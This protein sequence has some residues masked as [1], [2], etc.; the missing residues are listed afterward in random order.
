MKK[1]LVIHTGGTIA[2]HEDE[3]GGVQPK[4]TNPLFATVESL[5]SIA[6]IEVDDF[7]NIPSPHMTPELMFQLAERLKSRVGNESFDGVVIT[8]GTDTLEETAY[9]LDLL[10]DWEVPVV[11][12]GAMRSSNELGADGPH[13]FI[14]AVKTAATDEAKGKGVLVV[15][16]DEIHTAKNVT[17][18]HTSNV[19]TFQSPQ[20]GPI[21]IVTKRGVTF[22][23]APSY[24]ESYT[25]SSIDHRVVLLKAYAGMDGSVVDAIADTGI[26]GL[27]IEAFGQGNLPPAVV[28]SIKRLHQANIPVVLVSRSVSGIVQE[29]YAYEGGGRHLKD[30]GVIFTN[31][32]NGQKARL[33]L[34]VA[35]ELTTDRK[36]LQEIFFK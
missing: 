14:S 4:E 25:V 26:D 15:F 16:N 1:V 10:L 35:L 11:V 20:Y 8:H 24:K 2:M 19:A 18:T 27:V 12:T 7:L 28:P 31:G 22:H 32:L 30:L 13:N 33:K 23:H 5:T 29:T 36:K 6:S 17:K 9:L 34:L 21:G 3:K